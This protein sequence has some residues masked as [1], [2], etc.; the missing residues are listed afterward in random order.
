[1]HKIKVGERGIAVILAVAA[2]ILSAV[3]PVVASVSMSRAQAKIVVVDAGHGGEDGGVIGAKTGVK[4]SEINL[5]MSKTVGE[6]LK[7]MGFE[8]VQTRKNFGA[9]VGGK[10]KKRSDMEERLRIIKKAN[11]LAVVSLHMNTYSSSLRRGAQVFYAKSSDESAL[12][13]S[14][15]QS[16]LNEQFNLPDVKRE[17][18]ALTADKYIL[19]ESPAPAIIVECGFLS[20][21]DDEKNFLDDEYRHRIAYTIAKAIAE[22]AYQS[23]TA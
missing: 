13:A 11:P 19:R 20:N 4:E 5:Y 10:F 8:V 2:V 16:R 3:V 17:Y 15:V 7:G 9:L 21:P 14:V 23:P 6:Y 1:M 18:S 22:Y 12:F